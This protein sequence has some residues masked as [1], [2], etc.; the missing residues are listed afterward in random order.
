MCSNHTWPE[1]IWRMEGDQRSAKERREQHEVVFMAT[2]SPAKVQRKAKKKKG[3]KQSP[4][5]DVL[6]ALTK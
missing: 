3:T 5:V 6:A 2:H 1:R 4:S